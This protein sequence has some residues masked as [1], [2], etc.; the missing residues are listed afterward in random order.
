MV[1]RNRKG[2]GEG[3]GGVVGEVRGGEEGGKAIGGGEEGRGRVRVGII[4]MTRERDNDRQGSRKVRC[5]RW[6]IDRAQRVIGTFVVQ[7]RRAVGESRGEG[8]A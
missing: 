3:G 1:G 8:L 7:K 5:K 4:Y 6:R 2:R